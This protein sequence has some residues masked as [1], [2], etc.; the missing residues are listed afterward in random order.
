MLVIDLKMCIRDSLYTAVQIDFL[1][2][3]SLPL[4]S[5]FL[6]HQNQFFSLLKL[7]H[8][9]LRHGRLRLG[10]QYPPCGYVFLVQSLFEDVYKRQI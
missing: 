10:I 2:H 6:K 5:F 9:L 1:E 7:S 8:I 3:Y 4:Q